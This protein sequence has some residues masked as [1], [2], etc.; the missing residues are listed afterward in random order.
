VAAASLGAVYDSTEV[1]AH[2]SFGA[3]F[4]ESV[5][6]LPYF[7]GGKSLGKARLVHNLFTFTGN[8]GPKTDPRSHAPMKA[9]TEGVRRG[10]W[11]ESL[12]DPI[13]ATHCLVKHTDSKNPGHEHRD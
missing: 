8:G 2:A 9:S 10:L 11:M 6:L 7:L 4:P 3:G 5:L 13:F 1:G 12:T